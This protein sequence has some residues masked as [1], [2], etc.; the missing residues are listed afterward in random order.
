MYK[1]SEHGKSALLSLVAHF[2]VFQCIRLAEGE[3]D[4]K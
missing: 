4:Y 3:C 1:R 2:V